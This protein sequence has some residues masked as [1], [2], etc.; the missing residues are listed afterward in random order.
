MK[1]AFYDDDQAQKSNLE[2]LLLDYSFLHNYDFEIQSFASAQEL[3][4][5]PIDYQVLILDIMLENDLN[6]IEIA[7]E[8]RTNGYKNSIILMTA[9]PTF[10]TDGYEIEALRFLV[11]PIRQENL[12]KAL[13]IAFDKLKNPD[14]RLAVSF[15]NVTDYVRIHD[16]LYI[17]SR[18][19]FRLIYTT[20]NCYKTTETIP[21]LLKRLPERQFI[22]PHKSFLVN[23]NHVLQSCASQIIM[24][25]QDVVPISRGCQQDFTRKLHQFIL[26]ERR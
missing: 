1:V 8:L 14:Q 6:G 16:I 3:L 25:N 7:K 12:F 15:G 24:N 23:A 22:V 5:S 13:D 10:A 20:L 17:E 26:S 2:K 21:S 11:K 19:T 9:F 4:G 18:T